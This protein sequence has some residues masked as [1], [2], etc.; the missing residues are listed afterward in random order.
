MKFSS[1]RFWIIVVYCYLLDFN[2]FISNKNIFKNLSKFFSFV[3]T[4]Q[5][6]KAA[7][8]ISEAIKQSG[9]VEFVSQNVA[10]IRAKTFAEELVFPLSHF[11][12]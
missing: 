3:D 2:S 9:V 10:E 5:H 4:S 8:F 12:K 11:A 1:G 6:M 7:P